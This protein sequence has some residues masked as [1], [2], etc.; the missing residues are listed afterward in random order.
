MGVAGGAG[1]LFETMGALGLAPTA[2]QAADT[3]AFV[4]LR[5]GELG[6][7]KKKVVILGAGIAGLTSAYE[8]GKAGYECV[9]LEANER[10]G[11]RNWTVRGGTSITDLDGH[12]QT[13]AFSSGQYM[14]A[15]PARLP[16]WMIT[17]DYCRE[18]GVLIE[19]FT[20]QNADAYIYNEKTV[21][22]PIR[23]RTAKADV[24]GYVSELLAKATDQGSLDAELTTADKEKLLT[25]LQSFGALG[26]KAT[27]YAYTGTEHRGF[28]VLPGAGTEAGTQLGAVP[29]LSQVLASGVG[30]Y[31]PFEFAFDQA[32]MMYQPVGGMDRIPY[33]LAKAVGAHKIRYGCQVAGITNRTN[34]VDI[35]YRDIGGRTRT[36]SGDFCIA[37]LPPHILA[38]LPH[39]LGSQVTHALG[40]A[41]PSPVGKIG[42]EY[43]RRWWEEDHRIYGGITETDMDLSHVW[44]PSYNFHGKRGVVI[45]YYNTGA[46]ATAY[47]NLTPAA[48]EARAIAQGAKIHGPAY[49]QELAS[50]FSVAW[51]RTP[52]LEAGW[53]S[54]P[55]QQGPEYALLNQPAGN[56]YFAGDWLS[57]WI[58]WQ[59]GAFVSARK[60]VTDIHTRVLAG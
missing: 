23:Y 9:I 38:R 1:M 31:F 45:G 33:A 24:Y 53:V 28:S 27:G 2:A 21:G 44:Y 20:N 50:S 30:S 59:H 22:K 58:A 57:Y 13:A 7:R 42:L 12:R 11:G 55:N 15:G 3:P 36:E 51:H 18:L 52:F 16:Q 35:T 54:W 8:L 34:G 39:N 17:L 4:P 25:F 43:R 10:P 6:H 26:T 41:V 29:S 19:P 40:T 14:N 47:G 60:I 46:N 37:A 49:R 5:S 32:M 48:R 56:V